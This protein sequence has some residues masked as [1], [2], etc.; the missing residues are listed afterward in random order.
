MNIID[1][2]LELLKKSMLEDAKYN[3]NKWKRI[4]GDEMR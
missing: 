3:L 1:N 2:D 4:A